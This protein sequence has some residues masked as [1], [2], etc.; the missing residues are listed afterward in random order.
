MDFSTREKQTGHAVMS[1][2]QLSRIIKCP[3]SV[4]LSLSAPVPKTSKYALKGTELH[5]WMEDIFK[6]DDVEEGLKASHLTK[7]EQGWL[8]D[9][10][11]YY[12]MV[13]RTAENP[14]KVGTESRVDLDSWGLP[15]VY[16]TL[17]KRFN[18]GPEILHIFDWKFGKGVQ[19]FAE[20]NAQG[21]GYAAGA[22]GFPNTLLKEVH[23]HIVQPPLNHYDKWVVPYEDLKD[24]VWSVLT[25]AVESALSN[26]P[27]FQSGTEQCRWC[28]A[29]KT[30]RHRYKS[31]ME[32]AA[33]VFRQY[34]ADVPP[35]P[36]E[37]AGMLIKLRELDKIKRE[38]EDYGKGELMNG[39]PF[40]DFKLVHGRNSRKWVDE[41]QAEAWLRDTIDDPDRLYTKKFV[42]PP[43]AEKLDRGFKKTPGFTALVET[44][45]GKP[46]MV[47]M[48]DKREAIHP[49]QS[50]QS[51]FANVKA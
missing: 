45:P 33:E 42:T 21:L 31:T 2:S 5:E 25:P 28:P 48:S 1:P 3:G 8:L 23:I 35:S 49:N 16:G 50:A 9:A 22:A 40:G 26:Q 41:K 44:V 17:D 34:A 18:D 10:R 47:R 24:W 46:T 6:M 30:C 38:L 51:A 27:Q 13:L 32:S 7:E 37:L 4:G 20:N 12:L 11:D 14:C 15:Q 39:R 19:V 43:Q 36:E 29:N